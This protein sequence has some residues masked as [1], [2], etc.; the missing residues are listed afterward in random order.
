VTGQV[1]VPEVCSLAKAP[2]LLE[3]CRAAL[4]D[5]L[6][7]LDDLEV[8]VEVDGGSVDGGSVDGGSADHLV[9]RVDAVTLGS[10]DEDGVMRG[11]VSVSLSSVLGAPSAHV[12]LLVVHP[13]RR[14]RGTARQLVTAAQEWA[15]A[16]GAS[17]LTVGAGAPFYLFTGVDT[18]WTEALC[19]FEALG[20]QR[21]GAELDL[22]CPTQPPGVRSDPLDAD[23]RLSHVTSD[24]D[25]AA[26][27]SMVRR[28]FP[29]WCSEFA[30]AAEAG[31]V[32]L[33]RR[34]DDGEVVGAAA[35]SVSRFGVVGP[36]AVA[37]SGQRRGTGTRLMAAVLADLSTAGLRSAEIAWTSTVRFY[38]RSCAARVGRTSLVL[39][40]EL[41]P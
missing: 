21:V 27:A 25:A 23:L 34:G 30:R 9:R 33:A 39:R 24:V 41:D 28:E 16:G 37:P 13:A 6:L 1:T 19:C 35:H 36:V 3:L 8:L 14:R 18:R 32:V 10:W 7:S 29:Q 12:Q 31:T 2:Q 22:T 26:L 4:P 11:A 15:R 5:E 40:R 20:Y 38:A 17:F